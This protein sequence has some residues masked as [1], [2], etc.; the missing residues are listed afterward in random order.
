MRTDR[1]QR[2]K[3]KKWAF[4]A[5]RNG[6]CCLG[7]PLPH[8]NRGSRKKPYSIPHTC[9]Q[10]NLH[11]NKQWHF[12]YLKSQSIDI[13]TMFFGGGPHLVLTPV[14]LEHAGRDHFLDCPPLDVAW[15]VLALGC[16]CLKS[17]WERGE[18]RRG[19]VGGGS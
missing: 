10:K 7:I 14:G 2:A 8:L 12:F 17:C 6:R 4:L 19:E 13:A 3:K 15:K 18:E 11:K 1:L 9:T 5:Q 16:G